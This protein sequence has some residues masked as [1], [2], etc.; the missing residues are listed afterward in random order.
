MLH[1][2]EGIPQPNQERRVLVY[3]DTCLHIGEYASQIGSGVQGS[4]R[5]GRF[6]APIVH[7]AVSCCHCCG[8][9]R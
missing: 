8:N 5:R 2:S 9:S 1:K 7:A 4:L 6:H 3:V